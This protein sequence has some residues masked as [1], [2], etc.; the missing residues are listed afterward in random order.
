MNKSQWLTAINKAFAF[1]LIVTCFIPYG[2]AFADNM[3]KEGYYTVYEEGTDKVVFRISWDLTKGDNYLSSDNSYYEI[4]RVDKKSKKAF[5]KF[6]K[7]VDLPQIE[8]KLSQVNVA[9]VPRV[10]GIYSTHSDESY[11]PSDGAASIYGHGGIYDVDAALASSLRKKG[12]K[13]IFDRTL[14][15]P[16]DAYAYARSRRTALRLLKEGAGAILDIHRDAAPKEDY[17]RTINGTPATGVRLV[18]GKASTNMAANQQ[19]A[20]K[21]K[22]IADKKS[23]GLVKD[24]F[25][26]SGDYNQG[27][28]P[29][30]ILIEFGTDTHTKERAIK[31]ADMYADVISAVF[32]GDTSKKPTA[33]GGITRTTPSE[34]RAAGTGI[35]AAVIVAVVAVV[36]FVLISMGYGKELGSKLSKFVRE[37]FSSYMGKIKKREGKRKNDH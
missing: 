34:R 1:L 5:A 18:V 30:S 10:V 29:R 2:K 33:L 28:T 17:I 25:F 24:I 37:E 26:G 32:F 13:V 27:L 8:E 20:Y 31:A 11:I 3:E 35:F 36:G 7:K 9:N 23:P 16:H 21:M 14:H 22:A 15:L 19:L 6:I 4:T 12:I